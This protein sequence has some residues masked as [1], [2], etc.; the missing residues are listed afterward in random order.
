MGELQN[1]YASSIPL[2]MTA[3]TKTITLKFE[4][5]STSWGEIDLFKIA[6]G[7]SRGTLVGISPQT[8]T[9]SEGAILSIQKFA[10]FCQLNPLIIKKLNIRC[11]NPLDLPTQI[12]VK[13]ADIFAGNIQNQIV[14]VSASFNSNQF[15]N[16]IVTIPNIEVFLGRMSTIY[17]GGTPTG[18]SSNPAVMSIDVTIGNFISLEFALQ[19]AYLLNGNGSTLAESATTVISAIDNEG[20]KVMADVNGSSGFSTVTER[21]SI[22]DELSRPGITAAE[23]RGLLRRGRQIS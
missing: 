2:Y 3:G 19:Q 9:S 11:T 13:T 23:R 15:Q 21:A 10:Q 14:D 1:L 18:A 8:D 7:G 16:S 20:T 22:L 17:I 5:T 12:I 4:T 6:N